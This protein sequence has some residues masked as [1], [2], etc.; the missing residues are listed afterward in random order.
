[1]KE[2]RREIPLA[3]SRRSYQRVPVQRQ[4]H[5]MYSMIVLSGSP[6]CVDGGDVFGGKLSVSKCV[7]FAMTL[8]AST[9]SADTIFNMDCTQWQCKETCGSGYEG[10]C[11]ED[12]KRMFRATPLCGW[13]MVDGDGVFG[14]QGSVCALQSMCVCCCRWCITSA[15]G[16]AHSGSAGK[17]VTV[18][19]VLR[20]RPVR[21]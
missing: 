18:I 7:T 1:M 8:T 9:G 3:I 16:T 19:I 5:D 14:R 2:Y 6:G 4:T 13:W 11:S 21:M 20:T 10:A 12:A 17:P 15:I